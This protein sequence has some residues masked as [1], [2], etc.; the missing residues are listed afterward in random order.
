MCSRDATSKCSLQI[1]ASD[2]VTEETKAKQIDL[3]G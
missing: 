3:L 1:V 2:I